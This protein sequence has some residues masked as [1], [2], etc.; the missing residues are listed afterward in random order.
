MRCSCV[1]GLHSG[2][3][4]DCEQSAVLREAD[5]GGSEPPKGS[6]PISSLGPSVQLSIKAVAPIV[7]SFPPRARLWSDC[8]SFLFF[9][10]YSSSSPRFPSFPLF[11][12][13]AFHFTTSF[14]ALVSCLRRITREVPRWD[15]W[16]LKIFQLKWQIELDSGRTSA[17]EG[18]TAL[19]ES[20]DTLSS[21][22]ISSVAV[23]GRRL[24]WV[25]EP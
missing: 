14:C 15:Q 19:I 25:I 2:F 13:T 16:R 22:S 12:V 9:F 4:L 8:R 7:C 3:G 10:L 18:L 21:A 6:T 23:L 5:R 1:F 17:D 11:H 20:S 24:V